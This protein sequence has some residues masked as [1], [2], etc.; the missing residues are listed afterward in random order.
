MP[1]PA[2]P[3]TL[4]LV[5]SLATKSG[6]GERGW[7]AWGGT[8]WRTSLPPAPPPRSRTHLPIPFHPSAPSTGM[9]AAVEGDPQ[10]QPSAFIL[11][12]PGGEHTYHGKGTGSSCSSPSTPPAQ[13]RQRDA[14]SARPIA[15]GWHPARPGEQPRLSRALL[16][17][18]RSVRVAVVSQHSTEP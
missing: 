8:S 14:R 17:R 12:G 3:I 13:P 11:E 16:A 5:P 2:C 6:E 9:L 1:P 18:C 7:Q 10:S 4:S 15:H